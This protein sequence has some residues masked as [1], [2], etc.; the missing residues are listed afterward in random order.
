[1]LIPSEATRRR[2]A[3]IMRERH[4]GKITDLEAGTRLIEAD[5]ESPGGYILQGAHFAREG[6]SPGA[7][8]C[9]W[10]ALQRMPCDYGAYLSLA[11][12]RGVDRQDDPVQQ[13]LVALGFWKIALMDEVP[14][15]IADFY[16][17]RVAGSEVDYD[18][19]AT[20]QA[21][22]LAADEAATGAPEDARLSPYEFLNQIEVEAEIGLEPELL[23]RILKHSSALGPLWRAALRQWEE[24]G[25]AP[26]ADA[27]AMM[28]ALL[29][30]TAG[31][32]TALDLLPFADS[33]DPDLLLHTNWAIWRLGQRYPAEVLA[34]FAGL[35]GPAARI[36]LRCAA[37]EHIALLPETPGRHAAASGLLE[38][39]A[40]FAKDEEAAFLLAAVAA[41]LEKLG[42]PTDAE[43]AL[44]QYQ[45]LLRKSDRQWLQDELDAGFV[46][47]LE[48]AEIEGL[49]I[50]EICSER[51][52][53]DDDEDDEDEDGGEGEIDFA[54]DDDFEESSGPFIVPVKPGRNDPCW[55]GSGNK[56]KKCHLAA[57][58]AAERGGG[59]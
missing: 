7:E 49:T 35:T 27:L 1:M 3:E 39:F 4:E 55:C 57:D 13:R 45:K 51:I 52:L 28:I 54:D 6:D 24:T 19:P 15:E 11:E 5:P 47:R 31:P 14:R 26:A 59:A 20:Y 37:A 8:S 56:Y 18:D 21:L 30:E 33:N 2:F 44:R 25:N 16:R 34:V 12:T 29:G 46:G 48:D 9:W 43:R 22:A 42:R 58:E 50:E 53:M 17:D 41:T 10:Q 32:G 23:E 40:D 36:T 38:G